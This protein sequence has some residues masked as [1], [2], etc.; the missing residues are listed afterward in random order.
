MIWLFVAAAVVITVAV[1][2]FAVGREAFTLGGRPK[3][4]LFDLEEAVDFVAER[5]PYEVRARLSYDDV[6]AII[7]WH[8]DYFADRGV[9]SEAKAGAE[10][11]G[12]IVV[13]DDESVAYVLGRLEAAGDEDVTADDV[14]VVVQGELAYLDAIGA[15]GPQVPDPEPPV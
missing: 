4:A 10:G 2:L 14:F 9:P 15:I 8:L 1:A 5:L 6:R 3:Q 7:R 11:R 13:E 12:A